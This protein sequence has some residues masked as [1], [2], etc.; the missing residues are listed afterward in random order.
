MAAALVAAVAAQRHS[1]THTL[2]LVVALVVVVAADV[3]VVVEVAP[4]VAAV[5]RTNPETRI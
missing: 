1:K 5:T 4:A 2:R 3:V